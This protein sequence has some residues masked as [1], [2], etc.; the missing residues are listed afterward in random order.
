MGVQDPSFVTLRWNSHVQ[1]H[2][3]QRAGWGWNFIKIA[4]HLLLPFLLYFSCFLT[5]F[6]WE[7]FL[8]KSLHLNLWLN[9]CFWDK[10]NDKRLEYFAKKQKKTLLVYCYYACIGMAS[11]CVSEWVLGHR[12]WWLLKISGGGLCPVETLNGT[13]S[14]WLY[15]VS[16]VFC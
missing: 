6:F 11:I 1:G 12:E 9:V 7:L 2:L 13:Q 5:D 15:H 10:T 14:A 3:Y 4:P 8:N 16:M